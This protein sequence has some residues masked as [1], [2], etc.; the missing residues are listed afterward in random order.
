LCSLEGISFNRAPPCVP[1]KGFPLTEHP[2]VFPL[3]GGRNPGLMKI[4]LISR[5][6]LPFQGRSRFS[7]GGVSLV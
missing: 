2:L 6:F 4:S 3:E 5:N 1:W 7:G